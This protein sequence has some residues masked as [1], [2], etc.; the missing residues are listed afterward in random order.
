VNQNAWWFRRSASAQCFRDGA[1]R[2]QRSPVPSLRPSRVAAAGG[3]SPRQE[4]AHTSLCRRQMHA[5][6]SP[7]RKHAGHG[8]SCSGLDLFF[9][10]RLVRVFGMALASSG[11]LAPSVG[12]GWR[13]V[14]SCCPP[15]ADCLGWGW[16]FD[17]AVLLLLTQRA[18]ALVQQVYCHVGYQLIAMFSAM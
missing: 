12:H 7:A 17:V 18:P 9:F 13:L 6:C 1:A 15:C 5:F 16:G 14:Y 8:C 4:L 10:S 11:D 3:P 2:R